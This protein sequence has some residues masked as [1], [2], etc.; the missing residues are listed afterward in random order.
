MSAAT[1]TGD[2]IPTT[3]LVSYLL[4]GIPDHSE[5]SRHSRFDAPFLLSADDTGPAAGKEWLSLIKIKHLV[6]CFAGGL[7]RHGFQKGQHLIL[8]SP[9]IISAVVVALG[10]IAAGGVFCAAQPDL[11]EREYEDQ[12]RRDEPTYLLIYDEQ[13]QYD[14]A[15]TAW[16]K[17]GLPISGRVWVFDHNTDSSSHAGKRPWTSRSVVFKDLPHWTQLLVEDDQ[18]SSIWQRFTTIEE[19]EAP[20]MLFTTSGTSGLRKAAVYSHRNVVS[21]YHSNLLRARQNAMNTMRAANE[22]TSTPKM[23][24]M[25][26]TISISRAMGTGL[27]LSLMKAAQHRPIEVY[28]MS[29]TSVDMTPYLD[30][31]ERLAITDV[32]CAPFTLVKLFKVTQRS[33]KYDFSRLR[34]VTAVGAPCSE[35]ALQKAKTFLQSNGAPSNLRVARSLGMTEAG[36]LV[37]ACRPMEPNTTAEG[38]QGRIMPNVEA[39]IMSS[40]GSHLNGLDIK[41]SQGTI[42]ELWLR[43]PSVIKAYYKDDAATQAAF[44]AEGWFRSGD[45]GYLEDDKL[46]LLDRKKDVLKTPDSIPPS[47]IEGVLLEHPDVQDAGV[48]GIYEPDLG[49]QLVRAYIVKAHGSAM[50]ADDI[51]QWMQDECASTA[52][53]TAGAE[54][55]SELPRHEGGKLLR[56]VLKERAAVTF[57]RPVASL[58]HPQ[59]GM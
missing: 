17:A 25:L 51:C 20:C 56:R 15:L 21:A 2:E 34:S 27:P 32:S 59:V 55:L 41:L 28:F 45:I 57:G 29:K 1:N 43:G 9:N 16:T 26:H 52:H 30:A 18:P 46:F 10:T 6:L 12:F 42:G 54:F 31:V 40:L 4:D 53:L 50:T 37:S 19:T 38:Y 58:T 23:T 14:I 22:T 35:S 39:K 13:P 5:G 49:L 3:D 47:Y 7:V 48:V 24:R 11:K 33:C 44:T 36:N 8:V